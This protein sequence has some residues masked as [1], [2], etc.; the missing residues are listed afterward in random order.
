MLI[1]AKCCQ[2]DKSK[3]LSQNFVAVLQTCHDRSFDPITRNPAN[4]KVVLVGGTGLQVQL[5]STRAITSVSLV[6]EPVARI[7]QCL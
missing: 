5:S 6:N 4:V 2:A 1:I 7:M 3:I